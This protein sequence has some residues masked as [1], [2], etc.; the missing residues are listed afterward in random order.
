MKISKPTTNC[1]RFSLHISLL[2][3]WM[4]FLG[5]KLDEWFRG[6]S[7][8]VVSKLFISCQGKKMYVCVS[9][10]KKMFVFWKIWCALFS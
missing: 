10:G 7:R 6:N 8:K 5:T 9:G 1:L 4:L 2:D 3:V